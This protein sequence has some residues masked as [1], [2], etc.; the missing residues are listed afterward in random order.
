MK[1]GLGL[2]QLYLLGRSPHGER[3]LK[4]LIRLR[5]D[6]I[7]QSLPSRG[8]WIE[9]TSEK[10]DFGGFLRRSPHGERGLKFR[11]TVARKPVQRRSPHG[12]RGLK[13]VITGGFSD[14]PSRRSPHGERGL[15]SLGGAGQPPEPGVA[16]LTGSVFLTLRACIVTLRAEFRKAFL[17]CPRLRD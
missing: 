14:V 17:R 2:A 11:L 8:A 10:G 6:L 12:E 15:K 1:S 3:G 9:I 4:Y 13:S 7:E 16:P 5:Q